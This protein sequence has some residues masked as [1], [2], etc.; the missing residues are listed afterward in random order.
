MIITFLTFLTLIITIVVSIHCYQSKNKP[1]TAVID[2]HSKNDIAER[3]MAN[4]KKNNQVQD[5]KTRR[6]TLDQKNMDVKLLQND[7]M[8]SINTTENEDSISSEEDN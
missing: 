1:K 2:E 8:A 3:V 5:V 4:R 7:L 6:E